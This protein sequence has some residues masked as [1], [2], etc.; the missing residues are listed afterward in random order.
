MLLCTSWALAQQEA[1][2]MRF[3]HIQG[4]HIV[5]GYAGDIYIVN[6]NGGMARRLTT[7]IGYELFP[8][9]SPDGQTIA[10]T[11]QYDGNSEVYTIPIAGGA[12]K[13]LT[14]TATLGRDDVGDRMGPNNIVI[15]WTPDGKNIIYRTRSYTFN[16]F[17]GQLMTVSVDGGMPEPIPLE[18]SGF[19]SFNSDGTQLAYNYIF[20]EFRT[21]KRYEG[22]MADDIRVYD[23]QSGQSHRI[24]DNR[25]QDIIP[26]WVGDDIYYISDRDDYMNLYRYNTGSKETVSV[27][28]LSRSMTSSSRPRAAMPWCTKTGASSTSTPRQPGQNEKLTIFIGNDQ[29]Y[30]HP[31][32]KDLS[33]SLNQHS[34]S[35]GGERVLATAR[36]DIFSLPGS[37]GV[38]YNL[39]NSSGANDFQRPMGA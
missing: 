8:R 12:P 39:T 37:E 13:R 27:D 38:T 14:Y 15:G 29:V 34:L 36:G 10:F 35:P 16:D 24:T 32:W 6:A 28:P 17:T 19:C 20:R 33:R 5:F 18:N 11:A 1:R 3:P 25:H 23:T 9:I 31:E 21:W 2:L 7:H 22:G 4:N 30:A 26:M